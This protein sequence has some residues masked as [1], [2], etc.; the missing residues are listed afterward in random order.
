MCDKLK[1]IPKIDN[2]EEIDCTESRLILDNPNVNV[3]KM[4]YENCP[5]LNVNE[6]YKE[7]LNKVILIQRLFRK[8][9]LIRGIL[10][11]SKQIIPIWWDPECKGGYMYKKELLDFIE[12]IKY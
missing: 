5:W 3:K 6:E 7:N 12:K 4:T 9:V 11:V 2:I 1:E 8:N 10:R